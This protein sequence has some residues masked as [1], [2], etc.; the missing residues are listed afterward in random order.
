MPVTQH[1]SHATAARLLGLPLPPWIERDPTLHVT[2][3]A[4][5]EPRVRGIAGHLAATA[6]NVVVVGGLRVSAPV[7]TWCALASVLSLDDLAVLG[8]ALVR[9]QHPLATM[10]ELR[11]AVASQRGRRGVRRLQRALALVRPGTDSPKETVVRLVIIRAGLPEPLVN[12]RIVSGAG[13]FLALGDMVY[14]DYKVLVEYDG[15]YHFESD[16]QVFHDIDRLDAVMAEGWRVIRFNKTHLPREAY[17]VATVR[18]ALLE[19]G[20]RA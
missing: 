14:P 6:S 7:D 3:V 13:R 15:G 18:A 8:D 5:R 11:L 10:E 19:R 4:A 12:F 1:F 9:R 17:V 20:W 2:A 16:E